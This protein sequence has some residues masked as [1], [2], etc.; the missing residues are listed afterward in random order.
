MEILIKP[1]ERRVSAPTGSNLLDVMRENGIPVSHSCMA[2]RCG[3]CRCR[4][5]SGEVQEDAP[6]ETRPAVAGTPP[7]RYVLACQTRI[8]G[9]CVIEVPEPDEVVVHPTRTLKGVVTAFEPVCHDV[10]LL[11]LKPAKPLQFSPGQ[12]TQLQ[13]AP[14]AA[15]PYSP[16]GIDSDDELEYH[17]RIVPRGRVTQFI[18]THLQVGAAVKIN[19]PLGTCY[20][21]RKHTG[22]MLCIAGGTGFAPMLSVARGALEGGMTN[23]IH[24]YFGVRD[25]RDVYGEERLTALAERYPHFH[26]QIVLSAPEGRT[27]YRHGLVTEAVAESLPDLHGW[28]AY[29]AGPPVMVE[30]AS[31]LAVQRGVA[32][33]QIHADAFYATGI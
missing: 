17:I 19:G 14:D 22:P 10:R 31:L 30:A 8:S 29:L 20:L 33:E 5:V 9:D 27:H 11:R 4:V 7:G 26:Y 21:R 6:V 2:G 32:Q 18:E 16:A 12:Y 23:P 13:F 25:Q 1:L 24:F 15:R 3:T 28:R